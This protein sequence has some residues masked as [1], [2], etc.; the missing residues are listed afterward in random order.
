[1][2]SFVLGGG[3]FWCLDAVFRQ[4]KG[5]TVVE[6]GY[7]GGT[8]TPDYHHV[9]SGHSG[10]AEVINVTFDETIIPADIILD[11]YF[12]IHNPTTLNRQGADEGTQY[13]S[14]MFYAD[15]AQQKAFQAA[16]NRAQAV[17]DDPLVTQIVPL[18]AFYKAEEEH[19][20]YF[21][22][23]P[24]TGYCTIVIEPKVARARASYQQWFKEEE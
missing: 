23:N 20:D 6:S 14:V 19:Q 11:I 2:I 17:W 7:S 5:V 24:E 9:A 10:H 16:A 13:R 12:L 22:K 15:S 21:R 4:L 1:M 18:E 8:G 3:C